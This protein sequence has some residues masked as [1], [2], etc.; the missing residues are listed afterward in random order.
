MELLREGVE[1]CHCEIFL[2]GDKVCVRSLPKAKTILKRGKT[3]ALISQAGAYVR[4]G[5]FIQLGTAEIQIRIF[6]G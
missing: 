1:E 5:D 6:K 3:S 2:N 4:S